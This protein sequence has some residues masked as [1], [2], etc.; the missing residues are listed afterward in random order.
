MTLDEC[1]NRVT[2]QFTQKAHSQELKRARQEFF[3]FIGAVHEED[4][5]FENYMNAF[6]EWYI[7]ERELSDKDL[8]P[9]RLFYK[10]NFKNFTEEEQKAYNDLTKL[11]HS[12]YGVKKVTQNSLV[13][14]DLYQNEKLKIESNFSTAAFN[15]GDIFEAILVPFQEQWFFLK[16]FF[17]HPT[18]VKSFI[19]KEMKKIQ[20]SNP[21]VL[22]KTIF[23]FRRLRLKFDRYP[24]VSPAQIYTSE[25]LNRHA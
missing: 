6:I 9:V 17:S 22:L 19:V 18:E 3:G 25:E 4:S 11:R 16:T 8:S 15:T 23:R 24:Y 20:N 5:F 13:L 7:L 21:K 2:E 12:I 14:E 1:F 10:E